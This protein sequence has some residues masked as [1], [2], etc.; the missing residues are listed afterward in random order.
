[1][2]EI[3]VY[4]VKYADRDNFAMKYTDPLTGQNV[5]RSTGTSK[6]KEAEKIAAKWEAELQEGRYQKQSRMGWDDFCERFEL[7]GTGGLKPTTV[8]GYMESLSAFQ[9]YCRPRG[10]YDLT[11]V[12]MTAFARE[13]RQPHIVTIGKGKN[14]R[15][16]TVQLSEA[17]V[18][19]H[20]RHLRKVSRWAAARSAIAG[21]VAL[22][23]R[24]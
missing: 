22:C 10:V 23:Q 4:V 5:R 14:E 24:N 20:L 9:R 13:L 18:A 1:M 16:K 3:K 2:D 8:A 7:D 15:K 17:S 21:P 12:K 6:R 11:T 19:R